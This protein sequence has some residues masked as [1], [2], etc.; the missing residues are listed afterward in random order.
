MLLAYSGMLALGAAPP[1]PLGCYRDTHDTRL[2][3][4]A[5]PDMTPANSTPVIC[6][7]ACA[8]AG[9]QFTLIGIEDATQCFCGGDAATPWTKVKGAVIGDGLCDV[10]CSPP[11]QPTSR[12]GGNWAVSVYWVGSAPAP[13]P[14]PAPP[15]P[16]PTPGK[17]GAPDKGPPGPHVAPPA[18]RPTFGCP[19]ASWPMCNTS[20]SLDAR[21]ADFMSALSVSDKI[22]I[23]GQHPSGSR[24]G[25]SLW[26]RG[27]NFWTEDLH[28]ARIGCPRRMVNGSN[29]PFGRCPT[30]F[31]E[32]NTIGNSFNATLFRMV[33]EAISTEDRVFYTYGVVNGLS[34]FAPQINLNA[35]PLWG[36]NMECPGEDPYLT[37]VYAREIISAMQGGFGAGNTSARYFKTITTP[38]HFVGQIFE[39]GDMGNGTKMDRTRNDSR[40]TAQ[41]L[42]SY[43]LRP[44]RA[45][46]VDGGSGSFMCAY[47]EVPS[48][49]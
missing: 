43:Y 33:G 23:L 39:G 35:N 42:E 8:K 5:L 49:G 36:R 18:P 30:I 28:G 15:G 46:L 37:S 45:A 17:P 4:K 6:A 47:S 16:Q 32:A 27:Y 19:D 24:D 21:V 20:L 26:P 3:A 31:P 13:P 14:P 11:G 34:V 2:F 12:C 22:A 38:K 7:A 1:K 44:F 41:D 10:A 25:H 9:P 29:L 40:I 48:S